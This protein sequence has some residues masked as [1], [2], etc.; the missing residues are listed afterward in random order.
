M[1]V[2]EEDI[3]SAIYY[4][5]KLFLKSNSNFRVGYH[6]KKTTLEQEIAEFRKILSDPMENARILYE[7][8]VCEEIDKDTYLAEKAKI[9]EA[10]ERLECVEQRLDTHEQQYQQFMKLQK[11]LDKELPLDEV[12]D[13]IDSIVVDEG[14]HIEVKWQEVFLAFR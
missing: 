4:Q 10:R 8:L 14:R 7:Q 3:F 6:S 12:M 5:L 9:N 1:Y 11:V 13:C 2:R